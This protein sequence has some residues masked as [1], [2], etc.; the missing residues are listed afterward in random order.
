MGIKLTSGRAWG[1]KVIADALWSML[2]EKNT[3]IVSLFAKA[4]LGLG[5]PEELAKLLPERRDVGIVADINFTRLDAQEASRVY[6]DLM[7]EGS[8]K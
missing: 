4:C 5:S 1:D 3:Q 7:R 6:Q 2:K 8:K